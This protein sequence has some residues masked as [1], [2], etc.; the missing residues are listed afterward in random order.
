MRLL[1]T[2]LPILPAIALLLGDQRAHA[3]ECDGPVSTCFDA[4]ILWP[5]A[6]P[7][8][9]FSIGSARTVGARRFSFGLATAMQRDPVV[10]RRSEAGPAGPVPI[11]AIGTQVNTTFLLSYGVTDRIAVDAAMPV[12]FFQT[13]TG[14]STLSGTA[15][16]VPTNAVRDARIGA[17]WALLPISRANPQGIGITARFDLSIP[18]GD[19]EAFAA[20]RGVVAAPSILVEEIAGPFTFGAHFGARIRQGVTF[21]DKRV[22]SQGYL[23][24][25]GAW[26]FDRTRALA[27]TAE[28]FSLPSLVRDG[29]NPIQWLAG[30]RW[31]QIWGGDLVVHAGGGGGFRGSDRT[32][33]LEPTWRAALDLRYAPL[34]V[35][36]DGDGI[37][38]RD[39]RCPDQPEDRDG[40]RDED[41]CPDPDNDGDGIPDKADACPNEPESFDGFEDDDGCPEPDRDG[42]G[43]KDAVDKCP[44]QPEDK[45]GYQ[46]DDGC[47]DGGAPMIKC[48]D[49]STIREGEKC[50]VDRDGV[51]DELDACPTVAEDRDGIA[52]EDGCPEKDADEDGVPDED[53]QCPLVAETI[54][55]KDDADGCPEPGAKSLV[56]FAAGAIEVEGGARFAPGSATITKA[57]RAQIPLI[58]QRLGGLADRGVE[59]ITIEAWGDTAAESAANEALAT[60][61]AQAI[62]DALIATGIPEKLVKAKPGDLGDPPAKTKPNY[63]VTVRTKRKGPLGPPASSPAAVTPVAPSVPAPAPPAPAAP[64]GP[65]TPSPPPSDPKKAP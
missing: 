33:L 31:A 20:N 14:L 43:I 16:D 61:R 19:A 18:T 59:R 5:T 60:K 42:D 51:P 53:D 36:R 30:V 21:L 8:T 34:S 56:T 57:M 6:G 23:A 32:D 13:G 12:T 45:N 55:G 10:L 54:D 52:D 62:A 24:L 1:R 25:G 49:G 63:L 15:R 44:D 50:D 28:A 37:L 65:A 29:P 2:L 27:L 3:A 39:D 40:F 47:P 17:A 46:D 4:D 26:T 22:A 11:A 58:V 7:T 9:F 64:P 35:D 38:D 41:G 48:A